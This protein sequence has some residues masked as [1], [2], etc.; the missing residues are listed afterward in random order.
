MPPQPLDIG[1]V[2]R[3]RLSMAEN[4]H[5]RNGLLGKNWPVPCWS[6]ARPNP[7]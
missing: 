1:R 5:C 4:L 7:L 2:G 3:S 6:L